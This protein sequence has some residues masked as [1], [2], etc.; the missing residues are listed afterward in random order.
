ME[1]GQAPAKMSKAL[2]K[3]RRR[4]DSFSRPAATVSSNIPKRTKRE[5]G[6]ITPPIQGDPRSPRGEPQ[7][8]PLE[9]YDSSPPLGF[10][11][12]SP[13]PD[14]TRR[15]S[16]TSPG[17]VAPP[18]RPSY[19]PDYRSPSREPTGYSPTS[20]SYN[21]GGYSPK[22]TPNYAPSRSLSRESQ[23]S[24]PHVGRKPEP[25]MPDVRLGDTPFNSAPQAPKIGAKRKSTRLRIPKTLYPPHGTRYQ[26]VR[27]RTVRV[28]RRVRINELGARGV[29]RHRFS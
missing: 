6:D 27:Y 20:P 17:Y 25:Q 1:A 2:R 13:R 12:T 5:P 15:Y 3:S 7:T 19:P 23:H 16:P 21:P 26:K 28:Q 18:P 8:P 22:N 4:S 14:Q 10:R 11:N 9:M 29:H 24:V